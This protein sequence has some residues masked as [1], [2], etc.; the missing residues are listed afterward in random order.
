MYIDS[1]AHF[2][3]ICQESRCSEEEV[4]S[5]LKTDSVSQ[6]VQISVSV[7]NFD[8]SRNFA[9]RNK[10]YGIYFT[11]GIHPTTPVVEQDLNAMTDYLEKMQD[12]PDMDIF[13]GIGECGL[14]YYHNRTD[15]RMQMQ[16]FEHQIFLAKKMR[17]P[18]MVHT[19]DAW[20]DTLQT[21]RTQKVDSG[22]IHCFSGD[23]QAARDAMDLG[24]YISFA[25]NVTYKKAVNLHEAAAFVPL[26]RLLLETDAP[27]LSPVPKRGQTNV[28]GN[29]SYAYKFVADLKGINVRDV[30]ESVSQNFAE[31]LKIKT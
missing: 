22:I 24:F 4:L 25:G 28:P 21:L 7:E 5:Q 29:V 1:H 12:S 31:L 30:E 27:F 19:R 13:A 17:K 20:D 18:I 14:D 11:I 3:M 8:W 9:V 16:S 2:D 6:A 10:K 23:A 26:D 15:H